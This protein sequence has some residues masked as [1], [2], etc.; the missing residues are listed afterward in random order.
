MKHTVL[1][2]QCKTAILVVV[3]KLPVFLLQRR[4]EQIAPI[5]SQN[6]KAVADGVADAV[7]TFYQKVGPPLASATLCAERMD[8]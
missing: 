6:Q 7:L 8:G 5:L 4:N 3:A 1:R 2:V